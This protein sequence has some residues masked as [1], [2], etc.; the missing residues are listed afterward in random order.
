M[1]SLTHGQ[2]LR[3]SPTLAGSPKPSTTTLNGSKRKLGG[4][5]P[6]LRVSAGNIRHDVLQSKDGKTRFATMPLYVRSPAGSA[7][8][9]VLRRQCTREYKIEPITRKI[10]ELLGLRPRQR[11]KGRVEQWFGISLDEITRVKDNRYHWID[12]RYPLIEKR[13][14]R[15]DCIL[16]LRQHGYP[17]PPKSSCIGCP[18]HGNEFWRQLRDHSPEEWQD[19]VEF[20]RQIRTGLKGVLQDAY[21]HRSLVPLDQ[22]DLSTPEDRGQM[23]L[24]FDDDFDAECEGMCG[25]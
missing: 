4:A 8:E 13:M 17:T 25:V 23:T 2:T 19:A 15:W 7:P 5:I 11:V 14:T 12:N 16:W 22:V 21:V 3:Y 20:D 10:R 24:A 18:Y 9:G 1:V 6:I